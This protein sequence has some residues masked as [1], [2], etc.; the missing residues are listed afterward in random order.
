MGDKY[1]NKGKEILAKVTYYI[2]QHFLND[3]HYCPWNKE[4][5]F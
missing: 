3:W 1:K 4:K 5:I 2:T